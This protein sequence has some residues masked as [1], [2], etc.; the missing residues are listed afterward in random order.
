[1]ALPL[2]RA[3]Y[4]PPEPAP[5]RVAKITKEQLGYHGIE[6]ALAN[7]SMGYEVLRRIGAKE[8]FLDFNDQNL[9]NRGELFLN[10]YF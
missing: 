6:S 4:I 2:E 9:A 7:L 8:L 5:I 3:T 1:M 10:G